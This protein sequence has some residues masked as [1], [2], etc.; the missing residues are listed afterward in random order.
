MEKDHI[1]SLRHLLLGLFAGSAMVS[2]GQ[3]LTTISAFPYTEGFE[4]TQAWTPG[5]T[6]SDWTWGTP[7]HPTINSAAQGTKAWCVGSLAGSFYSNGQ[8]SW[9]ETP[10]FDLS[11]LNYPYLSFSVFWETEPN[12]DGAGFQY[13]PNGGITWINVGAVNDNNCMNTNWFNTANITALNLASPR[14]GWTGTSTTGGCASG[15]GLGSWVLA[16]HCLDDLPTNAPVKFRFIFGAGTQCNSFDGFAIDQFF[17]GEAPTLDPAINFTC[18]NN[19]VNFTNWATLCPANST[20]NFGDAGSGANNTGTGAST[21]HIYPG[22]GTYTVSLTMTGP[23]AEPVTITTEVSIAELAFV[24]ADVGCVPNS[25]SA[26]AN[27]TGSAGPF[28]YDW[29][30]GNGSTQ[31]INGLAPGD[32]TV[33]VQAT[34]MCP[35][36]GTTT[37]NTSADALEVEVT[38]TDV[39]CAGLSGGTATVVVSG[40]SGTNTYAW[41]PTGGTD[42]VASGLQAGDYSCVIADDAGCTATVDVSILEPDPVVL[43]VGAAPELCVGQT[44]TL[45][46]DAEG[47]VPNYTYTWSPSGPD[48]APVVATDYTVFATDANGCASDVATFSVDVTTAITP[49]FMWDVSSGCAPL[50]VNFTETNLEVGTRAWT[51]GDGFSAGDVDAMEHCFNDPGSFDV[52]L[53]ITTANGCTGSFTAEDAIAVIAGPQAIIAASPSVALVDDPTFQFNDIGSGAVS[54]L[55]SFGDPL[56]T[57]STEAFPSFTYPGVDCYTVRLEVVGDAGC[58][59]SDEAEV[60]VEDAFGLFAPNAF[61]P[62]NDGINDGFMVRTTVSMPTYFQLQIF[63]RWGSLLFATTDPYAFWTGDGVPQGV[64]IWQVRLRD[65]QE[66]LQERKGH[67]VLIR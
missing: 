27:I 18:A 34:G 46:A 23:C 29:S 8:Q 26:T 13:S 36:Q 50:C 67:V 24:T 47:G 61:S 10:C 52:T 57:T 21:S 9:L 7:A 40:G 20:W 22:A 15:G 48:I 35:V 37:V 49:E 14:Q 11:A 53:S 4:A 2:F 30:P 43:N 60:C 64:F 28:T 55:W 51:F 32:Y 12:Y 19:T 54:Q 44:A 62:N 63:D 66:K 42:A 3:C 33:L 16:A 6:N 45:V 39:S 38:H 1:R 31:T 65:A 58:T 41:S 5:G 59:D 25:G 56:N 17:I